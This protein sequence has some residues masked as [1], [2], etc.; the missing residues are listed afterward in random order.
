MNQ[1]LENI[2]SVCVIVAHPDDEIL[3]TG[4]IILMHPEWDCKVFSLC[5]ASDTDRAPKFH[6]ALLRLGASGQMADFDDGPEQIP[7]HENEV[8]QSILNYIDNKHFDLIL[9]HGP[10]GEYTRHKRHEEVSKAVLTL[11]HNRSL[12][13]DKIWLF[14]YTD[15]NRS[16]LPIPETDAHYKLL[17]SPSILK[18]KQNIIT[19][20][21]G[22]T[23]DSWEA[24]CTP[25]EEAFWT[26]NSP[27]KAKKWYTERMKDIEN[28]SSL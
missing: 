6:K 18:D 28:F 19:E 14:A 25:R 11:W 23:A 21:Y 7:L 10:K 4:G 5:R 8:Q 13:A 15:A 24:R 20:I 9:S 17:L 26:F 2:H 3:W 16:H 1:N 27:A 12:N 22:F